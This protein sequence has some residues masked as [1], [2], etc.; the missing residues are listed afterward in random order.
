MR[1]TPSSGTSSQHD[2]PYLQQERTL[3]AKL[4][5]IQKTLQKSLSRTVRLIP[6]DLPPGC[7]AAWFGGTESDWICYPASEQAPVITVTHA[8]S[9]LSLLHCGQIRDG[10]R[11]MCTE[12]HDQHAV[13]RVLPKLI[14]QS[15]ESPRPL[16]SKD[17]ERAADETAAALLVRCGCWEEA[18]S[19]LD[20]VGGHSFRC[21]G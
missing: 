5:T 19:L 16:F 11:F 10:G 12:A 21:W 1:D 15:D 7:S 3:R 6:M 8:A 4:E 18:S 13:L 20:P 9:H 17:E 14:E 2:P